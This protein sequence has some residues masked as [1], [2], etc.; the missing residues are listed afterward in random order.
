MRF[1]YKGREMVITRELVT[2]VKIGRKRRNQDSKRNFCSY[3]NK[4]KSILQME[5][6][7]EVLPLWKEATYSP[8]LLKRI[9][10]RTKQIHS[11]Q[12]AVGEEEMKDSIFISQSKYAKNIVKKFGL[13]TSKPKRTPL[14]THVKVTTDENRKSVEVSGYWSMV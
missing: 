7:L 6:Q 4:T 10:E 3:W 8:V 12:D 2:L 1:S 9:W 11:I 13:E 5:V 14:A